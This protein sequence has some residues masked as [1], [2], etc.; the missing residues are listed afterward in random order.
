MA[1][2]V[3]QLTPGS[4][5]TVDADALLR[6]AERAVKRARKAGAPV[7]LGFTTRVSAAVDPSAVVFA[8]RAAGEDW[9]CFEQPDR[10]GSALAALGVVTRL[11]ASGPSRFKHVSAA[12]RELAASAVCDVAD[13]PPGAGLVAVGGFAF[14]PDGGKSP[15]WDGFSAADLVVPE[16]SLARSGDDVRLT[17]ATFAAPDDVPSDLAARLS[18]RAAGLR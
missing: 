2:T 12:W 1:L 16:V 6:R 17:L 4:G 9:F 14:G 5:L 7:L 18:A 11:T 8:S 3:G 15:H 10:G 13:G